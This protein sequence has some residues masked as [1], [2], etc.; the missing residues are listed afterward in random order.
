M[1]QRPQGAPQVLGHGR[2]PAQLQQGIFLQP[3]RM[4]AVQEAPAGDHP[5]QEDRPE[6]PTQRSGCH[7]STQVSIVLVLLYFVI[8]KNIYYEPL[9]GIVIYC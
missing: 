2:R 1:G 3:H 8:V 6:R 4:A 5:G 7:V 9:T